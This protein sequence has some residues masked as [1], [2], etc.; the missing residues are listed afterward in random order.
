[1]LPD[2]SLMP[3]HSHERHLPPR[4]QPSCARRVSQQSHPVEVFGVEVF[5]NRLN[6][7]RL[8]L[9]LPRDPHPALEV[10]QRLPKVLGHGASMRPH[11]ND[12]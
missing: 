2:C 5:A 11:S 4:V 1:V 10:V 8:N 9:H 7:L 3:T 12:G 6:V